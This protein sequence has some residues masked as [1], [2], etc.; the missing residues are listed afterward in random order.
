MHRRK[1]QPIRNKIDLTDRTQVRLLKKR[2]Q[3]SEAELAQIVDKAGNS[4]AAIAKQAA[5]QRATQ[6]PA[7]TEVPV[8]VIASV[9]PGETSVS[10]P[11]VPAKPAA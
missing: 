4:I 2:L 10:E 7:A 3:L 6:L 9:R 8:A 11:P 1:S 5:L